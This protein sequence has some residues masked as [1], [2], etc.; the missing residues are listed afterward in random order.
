M[1]IKKNAI[2]IIELIRRKQCAKPVKV[3]IYM[4][5]HPIGQQEDL[6][7]PTNVSEASYVFVSNIDQT[8]PQEVRVLD[9][10]QQEVANIT[11]PSNFALVLRKYPNYYLE[12]DT[13]DVKGTPVIRMQ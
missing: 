10:D 12:A 9:E 5:I 11:I 4:T 3:N 2:N 1:H 13:S 8:T 7:T 6:D